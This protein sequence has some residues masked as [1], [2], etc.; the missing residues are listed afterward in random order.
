MPLQQRVAE[1]IKQHKIE[2]KQ[3]PARIYIGHDDEAEL[4]LSGGAAWLNQPDDSSTVQHRP[5]GLPKLVGGMTAIYGESDT[6]YVK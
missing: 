5:D 4:L 3:D 2:H 6:T 1:L